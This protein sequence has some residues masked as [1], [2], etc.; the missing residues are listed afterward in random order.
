MRQITQLRGAKEI[1]QPSTVQIEAQQNSGAKSE[2]LHSTR[3][4]INTQKTPSLMGPDHPSLL[5]SNQEIKR[6]GLGA[7]GLTWQ[8]TFEDT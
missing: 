6:K 4:L 2:L 7:A 8:F 5:S 1:N 3:L